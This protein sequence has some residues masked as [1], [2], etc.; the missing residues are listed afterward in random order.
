MS[1]E[2]KMY[3]VAIYAR[4]SKDDGSDNES[5]SIISQ[6][7]MVVDYVKQRGWHVV[8]IY[9]DDGYSGTNFN[10]PAFQRM[11]EDIKA[12]KIDCLVY[13]CGTYTRYGTQSC[14]SHKIEARD[15]INAVLADINRYAILALQDENAVK[16]LQKRLNTMEKSEEK[17]YTREK[18]KLTKR[19]NELDR[20][21]SALY[22]DKV[23]ERVLERNYSLM[24]D[25]YTNEQATIESRLQD[26]EGE[27]QTVGNNRQ[28]ITDF[29]SLM[30]NYKGISELT[31][32]I[33]N[34]LID[35]IVISESKAN[36]SG[37]L[38]QEVRIYYKF[39]GSIHELQVIPTSRYCVLPEKECIV[40]GKLF[41]PG[42]SVA[43]F[44]SE[45]CKGQR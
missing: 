4:L 3:K 28:G 36:D 17:A 12:E 35:K 29:L 34:T 31:S 32:T 6:K 9:V 39:V 13:H 38:E 10:R 19:L 33:V 2:R 16:Q 14:T 21:F 41:I 45:G 23:M 25:K 1:K 15:L 5:E 8:E 18:N 37:E 27:L 22:E 20:L 7:A 26:I 43:R 11:L 42:S 24:A 30:T 40:C 44:C